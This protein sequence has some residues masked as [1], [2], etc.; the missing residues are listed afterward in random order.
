MSTTP[1]DLINALSNA[2]MLEIDD[3]HAWQFQLDDEQ[4]A[5]HLAGTQPSSEAPLLNIECMDGRALRKWHFSLAQVV[6]ARFDGEADAWRINGTAGTHLIKCFT[7]I[8]GD[9]DDLPD[10]ASND[11]A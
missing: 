9:N 2:D 3:L 5:Q 11:V 1:H 8:S 6:A 4:L 10:D 7:A